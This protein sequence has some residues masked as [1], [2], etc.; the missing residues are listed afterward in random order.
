MTIRPKHVLQAAPP[1][2][3]GHGTSPSDGTSLREV[4][5]SVSS[6]GSLMAGQVRPSADRRRDRLEFE[7][8]ISDTS[9]SLFAASPEQ[10]DRAIERALERVRDFFQ[11]DRCGLLSVSADQQV[12]T[13]RLASYADGVPPVPTDVNMAQLFP[14]SRQ[15]LLDE[16][17]PVRVSTLADLPPEADVE[18]ESWV[19]MPIRSALT[20]PIE[21]GGIVSHL[22]SLTTVHQER[23]WPDAF[24]TRLRV[25][26]EM[27]VGAV[28]RQEMFVGL[29]DAEERVSL[30]ADSAE[31]GL[32]TLDY[33]T[34]VFWATE[35]ARAILG[36]ASDDVLSLE[37]LEAS[38]HPEDRDLV[39]GAIERSARTGDP[40][41]VEY[42]I[43]LPGDGGVRWIASRGRP[44]FTPAGEPDRLMGVSIDIT[45]RRRADEALRASEARLVFCA[46][47]AGLAFYLVDFAEGAAYADDRLRD[48]CGIP[49]DRERGLQALEFWMEHLH[50]DD[51]QRV[52]DLR[53]QLHDGRL[54]RL[55]LEYRYLHPA[56]GQKWIQHLAGVGTRDATGRTVR[57]F[58]VLRDITERKR[59]EEE[60]RDLSRRLIGAHEEERALLARELH[61]DVTQRL[62]VLAIEVGRAE[63]A[64]PDGAQAEAMR[65]VREGLVRLSE[66]VHTLAYQLHPSVLEELGLAE[67]IQTECERIGRRGRVDLSVEIDPRPAAV[68]R[69]AALCLFRVAQGALNNVI[70]HA[71]ASTASVTLRQMDG[72]LLLAV[73]DDGVGFDQATPGKGRHLG[74]ASMRE[75]V[76]LVSGTLDIESAPGRGTA[77]VAWVP[78]E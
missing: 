9:A 19:Q 44:R 59:A 35:R 18:R 45:D 42:R 56:H 65:A 32:W 8:L 15:R 30:A 71:G 74:L 31:A 38:V 60:L 21:T 66:D 3:N 75:R 54:E 13:V 58:G 49:A 73:R 36:H 12:V 64:A 70:R 28:E 78:L 6:G 11:A 77:I 46:D 43:V 69:D 25:L 20:L 55:S 41:R 23:E 2:M 50:P 63:L 4:D 34:G 68:A 26:G 5:P 7:T 29:R 67:A 17:A 40:L 48:L 39:R 22:M 47:L 53:R 52:L 62:A 1:N 16:R 14:W 72:G 51:R 37:R 61:D 27:L 57:S 33:R 24:V 76:G 10:V